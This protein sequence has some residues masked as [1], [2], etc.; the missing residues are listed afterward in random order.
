MKK[1]FFTM[2]G[3]KIGL[4]SSIPDL[5]RISFIYEIWNSPA[6]FPVNFAEK[7]SAFFFFKVFVLSGDWHDKSSRPEVFCKKGILRNFAKLTG[8]HQ[9]FSCEFWE[10][11]K[12]TFLQNASRGCFC[13]EWDTKRKKINKWIK[14]NKKNENKTEILTDVFWFWFRFV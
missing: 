5:K 6:C 12:N 9:V 4:I 14:Q 7:K 1:I 3:W 13:Q 11:S 10:I 8:K 2:T